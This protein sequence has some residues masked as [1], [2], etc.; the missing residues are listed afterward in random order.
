M[1]IIR[2]ALD[3]HEK[4]VGGRKRTRRLD[5]G[6]RYEIAVETVVANLAHSTVFNASDRW[7]AI[8]TGNGTRGFTRYENAAL[9]KPLRTL[10]A[11]LEALGLMERR[12]VASSVAPTE[13]LVKMVRAAGVTL[14][15]FGRL[16]SEEVISL[17]RKRKIGDWRESHIEREWID[18]TDAPQ[19][20]TMRDAMRRIN[21]WLERASIS[22]SMMARSQS[23]SMIGPCDAFS[24]SSRATPG[25]TL[26]S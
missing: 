24:S 13:R 6:R 2:E 19:T 12:G 14:A 10:L 25:A 4:A 8:L 23:M 20:N 22:S 16:D 21:T 26:R 3:K 9:G 5:D 1:T 18:Y 11:G 17:S 7:L 15:D